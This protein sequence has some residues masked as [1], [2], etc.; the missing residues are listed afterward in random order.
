MHEH[1]LC[2]S[3]PLSIHPTTRQARVYLSLMFPC[4]TPMSPYQAIDSEQLSCGGKS[5]GGA[6][7]RSRSGTE[8]FRL[9]AIASNGETWRQ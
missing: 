3:N 8:F 9:P 1:N 2:T 4:F 7:R 5:S 6:L